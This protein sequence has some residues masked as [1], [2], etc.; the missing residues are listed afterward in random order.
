LHHCRGQKQK[1]E[2]EVEQR[3]KFQGQ[4]CTLNIK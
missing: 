2:F 1:C 3:I 4:R